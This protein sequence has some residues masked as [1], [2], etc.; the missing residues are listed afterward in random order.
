MSA[1][2]VSFC[3]LCFLGITAWIER[4][5]HEIDGRHLLQVCIQH[6]RIIRFDSQLEVVGFWCATGR[7]QWCQSFWSFWI[8]S[9]EADRSPQGKL[10][11]HWASKVAQAS[12]PLNETFTPC[13]RLGPF[14]QIGCRR[15]VT[16]RKI[17]G[18]T[19]GIPEDEPSD[20]RPSISISLQMLSMHSCAWEQSWDWTPQAHIQ[21]PKLFSG[22]M[23]LET[24]G[25]LARVP[26]A[27]GKTQPE[28][29]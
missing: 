13:L 20:I 17:H 19:L 7:C 11:N 29:A 22:Q 28:I 8:F 12:Q 2:R 16:G 25:F 27:K 21:K 18:K 5:P 6:L 1:N 4:D 24:A 15:G 3:A 26:T 23:G 9:S 10:E 14:L